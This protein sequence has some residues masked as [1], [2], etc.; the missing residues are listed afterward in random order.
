[1]TCHLYV[2]PACRVLAGQVNPFP[3]KL[4]EDTSLHFNA[5]PDQGPSHA[6]VW[7]KTWEYKIKQ[8]IV[9]M[10]AQIYITV[11]NTGTYSITVIC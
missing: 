6:P 2:L 11:L 7:S 3:A 10:S 9:E 5:D 4:R 8:E 1:M